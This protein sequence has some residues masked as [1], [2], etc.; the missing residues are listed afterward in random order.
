MLGFLAGIMALCALCSLLIPETKGQTIADIENEAL[1][2][3]EAATTG[4]I[5]S[6]PVEKAFEHAS[7]K[8]Y[9]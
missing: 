8:M 6:T 3:E 2:G 7:G 9:V 4:V 1:Y 5:P